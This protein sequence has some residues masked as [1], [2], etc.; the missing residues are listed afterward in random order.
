MNFERLHEFRL[1]MRALLWRRRL[2]RDLQAEIEFHLAERAARSGLSQEE[3]QRRFG[4]AGVIKES[5]REMWTFRWV[6]VL[7]QDLRYAART[8]RKSPGFTLV[9][10]LTLALGIG[11]DTAI[12]SLVDSVLVRPLPY[13]EPARLVELWGNVKRVKVERR[14]ASYPDFLDW[15]GQSRSFDGMAM[16][17][18]TVVTLTD[19]DE[20]ERVGGEVVSHSYFGLLGVRPTLG[21]VFREEEDRVPQRDAVVILSD[22]L[23]KR[24]FGGDA[25]VAG[26]TLQIGGKDFTILGV[27]PEWF[28]GI[29]D[30]AE[31][32]IP[33]MMWGSAADL[34]ER[35]TRS[36]PVLARLRPG[37]TP[38]QAQNELDGIAR[39]LQ[40]AY[41]ATNE[42]R[43][44][45]VAQLD[46]ELL[47]DLRQPLIVLLCAVGFVLL[48][49]CAN[50]ASLMLARSE[51]RQREIAMRIALGAG[52][53]R[54]LAQLLTES[55]VLALLG[56]AAGLALAR[57]G[58]RVLVTA[59]PVTFP[60]FIHPG[61]D[62]RV[63]LFCTL[64]ACAAGIALGVAP[65]VQLRHADLTESFKQASS[66]A[67]N[68]RDSSRFRG[69]LVVAE[70]AFAMLLL[71]GAG[72]LIRSVGQLAAI[73]PG[74]D[75]SH[76]LTLRVGLPRPTDV[77]K[78]QGRLARIPSVEAVS[79]GSDV[80]LDGGGATFYA[81]EGQP[82]VTAQNRPR[83]YPHRVSPD[84]FRTLRIPFL[85]GRP[86]TDSELHD[87]SPVVIVSES[88]AKRFW[89]G[90]D[91]IGKRIKPGSLDSKTPWMTIVGVVNE[92]KYRGL[93]NN[94]TA[95][96]D[97]FVPLS[98]PVRN[99]ALLIRTSLPPASLAPAVRQVLHESDATTVIFGVRT[100]E[101]LIARQTA[102]SRFTGWLMGIFAA[103]ALLLAMVGIYGVMSY[104]VARRT[105]EI[106]IRM[107]LGAGRGQ[108][109]RMIA[110]QG[111]SLIVAGLG[112]GAAFA[113]ALARFIDTML[114]NVTPGDPI[115]F[116]AAAGAMALVSLAAGL[117][118]A[119]R[120]TRIAPASA[121]RSE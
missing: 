111:M 51:S 30:Q 23:W 15:R 84:F 118:P 5:I 73:R 75:P 61:I 10:A 53:A 7:L 68:C 79:L 94:P 58:A 35:G 110:G 90:Q 121:L 87:A 113:F 119:M 60:S 80:P 38:A 91:P 102:G 24:R 92:V 45:E 62:L 39:R 89:P 14:G 95:D 99:A 55:C 112:I 31:F 22:G 57:W 104:S 96:P 12:F 100:L 2:D 32:W 114:Y 70:V 63:A 3:A 115:A 56:A 120:A 47:G 93:P 41:P 86:F 107:A 43:A 19:V 25:H 11:A 88:L 44:V 46:R 8:L 54:V 71:T 18:P 40:A 6:E 77:R 59:S 64:V 116:L 52:R 97:M 101:E 82:P 49:A 78:L 33:S 17:D 42:G 13:A 103:S 16:V 66:H 65:A 50:V 105:R 109:L 36:F 67:A 83:A 27:M 28:H 48:I 4:N 106:G 37:I 85:A 29:T 108:V 72:L 34:A 117:G 98:G 76:L 81:A 20:P 9:A 1:R 69:T 26:R 74:Y 21:R